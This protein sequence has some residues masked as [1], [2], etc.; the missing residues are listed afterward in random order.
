[1]H[2]L[3][4]E[5]YLRAVTE[6]GDTRKIV[7][8]RDIYSQSGIKLVA[9][10]IHITSD[11]YERLVKHKFL[12]PLDMD[13]SIENTLDPKAILQD[14]LELIQTNDK[15][16][17][18]AEAIGKDDYYRRIIL[19]IQLPAPLAFKLTVARE[20]YRHIYQHSLL[21][22]IISVYL[23]RCDEMISQEAEWVATAALFQDIGL[24]HIDPKLLEPSHV[25]SADERRHLYA[26]PLTAYLLLCEFPDLPRHIADAVLEH[27]ER[28]DGSGY[29]RG[30]HGEKISRYGQILAV[31]ELAAK[32]F[33]SGHPDSGHP[34]VPW[35]KLEV[36]LKLNS[37]RYGQGFIGHLNI[38]RDDPAAEGTP[39]GNDPECL[40]AQVRLIAKLF[41][42]FNQHS[43]PAH[44]DEIFDFAQTRLAGLRLEL[45]D[46][47]FDPRDPEG[48]IQLF[49]DDPEC[50][51]EYAPLLNEAL[52]RFKSL[53]MEISRLWPK[54]VDKYDRESERSEHA[55]LSE[56]KLLLFTAGE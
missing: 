9:A 31:A 3:Q 38:L 13:L 54:E 25:M 1:M 36:M 51:S 55:W 37:R 53:A 41:E 21:L 6:L 29:P 35:K 12:Q 44:R 32:A 48:L 22:L 2:E 11:L 4:D 5:H 45:F 8:G 56:M 27:H 19:A 14:V 43:D 34:G 50:I 7:A 47:G 30:L 23:A 40:V 26:H 20:K 33:D 24:L 28:M 42:D 52:W 39:G 16:K 15:L 49:T 17:K 10:G 46:A 18:M